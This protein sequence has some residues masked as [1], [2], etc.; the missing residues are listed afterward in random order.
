[1]AAIGSL[2]QAGIP[3]VGLDHLT[4]ARGFYSRYLKQKFRISADPEEALAFL[5]WLG[6]RG[7]GVLMATND[8]YIIFVAKN[9]DRLAK[10][11]VLTTPPWDILSRLMDQS[12]CY[13]IARECGVK[14]P[15][16]FKPRDEAEMRTIVSKLDL[17]NHA[18]LLKTMPGT[19][20]ADPR[21]GRFTKVAGSDPEAIQGNCLAIFSRLR[22]F[23][24]IVQV[25]PGEADHCIGVSM[26]VDRNHEPVLAYSIRRLKL[27]TYSRSGGF[28][29]PYELGANVYCESV[30]DD[31]ASDAAKRFVR[32]AQ[33]S[34]VIT[35]E[36]RRDSRNG[37][38]TLIKTD[39]RFVR[40]TSL[41]T[42]LGLDV[43][44]AL[45]Q[46]F[47]NGRMEAAD[48][49]AE[50]VAWIWPIPYLKTLWVN[51][52]NRP[53]RRELF[54]LLRRFHRIKALAFWHPR[55]P[56]PFLIGLGLWGRELASQTTRKLASPF[57]RSL[58]T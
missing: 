15:P 58:S 55:D 32:Q 20:P 48:N 30:R 29:H 25:V 21:T 5:T 28:V 14:T 1:M 27:Y 4:A 42:A 54:A 49:Y 22:E 24:M 39:P 44:T 46:V 40:A 11:F 31:E 3:T 13:T 56:L 37:S 10:H 33:Y 34:G 16:F 17:D 8:Q 52:S 23:P 35:V 7:G 45:Y 50:G 47:T 9:Y 43:P 53:V 2:G 38:L 26:V 6:E 18:Y 36:F 51:R 19:V 57:K 12:Q 41:S